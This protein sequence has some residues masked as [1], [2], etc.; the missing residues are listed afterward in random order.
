MAILNSKWPHKTK[1]A[2][3][4]RKFGFQ[5][6]I[7]VAS[8]FAVSK[9][10]PAATIFDSKWPPKTKIAPI[11]MKFGFKVNIGVASSFPVSKF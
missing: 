7:G 9:F 1:N 2:L 3:I 11:L 5:V 4:S 6:H 8:S 10:Y